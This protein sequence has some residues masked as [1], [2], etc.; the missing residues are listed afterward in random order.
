M[1][2]ATD[3]PVVIVG[4]GVSGLS[5]AHLLLNEKIPVILIEKDR[6]PGGLAQTYRY[7]NFSFD[8]GPHR[9]HTDV[10]KVSG[11]V[12]KVIGREILEIDRNSIVRFV[13][14]F[15][16]WPLRPSH[17]LLKFPP[18][19][20]LSILGDLLKLYRKKAP[21]SF[22]DQITNMYGETL[23]RNFFEG[24][25]SKFLGISP[26][27]TDPDWAKTGID[28][29][30]IDKRI[31][32]HN[33]WQL[34]LE[35]F[36]PI[37]VPNMKFIY[38]SGGAGIFTDNLAEEI[39]GSGGDLLTNEEIESLDFDGKM[40]REVVIGGKRVKPS[41]LVWTGTIHSLARLLDLEKPDLK[42]LSLVCYNIMMKDGKKLDFQW[43]YHGSPEIFF[44]RVSIPANFSPQN[45][46]EGKRSYCVEVSCEETD[47]VYINPENY[48]GRIFS[49]MIKENLIGSDREVFSVRIERFPWAY[50]IYKLG[51]KDDLEKFRID[52]E[53]IGNLLPA[54]R[55]GR[56]WYNNMDHCIEASFEMCERIR[57]YL[58]GSSIT[59]NSKRLAGGPTGR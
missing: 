35:T 44:S 6:R 58:D 37:R 42:Y 5:L 1:K 51:Y 39:A 25:S 43:C 36:L 17:V 31:K 40:I 13:D 24:Y 7:G 2:D 3:R 12:R 49:D 11:F 50:P 8:V 4:A 47:D 55:L 22:K 21:K 18:G 45:T 59:C 9:F 27:L 15:Y 23:Y 41:V 38:P 20:A 28:R 34:I 30:I 56:F 57:Q 26:E 46:P 19:I 33:L 10:E 53:G 29:A 32:M 52:L 14:Q 54:G 16:P 48:L